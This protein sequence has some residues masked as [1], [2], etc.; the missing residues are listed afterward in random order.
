VKELFESELRSVADSEPALMV[1]GNAPIHFI[2]EAFF[3]FFFLPSFVPSLFFFF[4]D[5]L[6]C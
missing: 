2:D 3:F 4:I 5:V 6:M 1:P